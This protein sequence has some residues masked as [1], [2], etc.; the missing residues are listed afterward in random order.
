MGLLTS[1]ES[2]LVKFKICSGIP[3][4]SPEIFAISGAYIIKDTT[5]PS[6]SSNARPTPNAVDGAIAPSAMTG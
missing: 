4:C 1:R 2:L 6:L 5:A 3:V